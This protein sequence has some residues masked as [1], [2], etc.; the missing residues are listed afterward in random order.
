[1]VEVQPDGR[2][3]RDRIDIAARDQLLDAAK[4][5]RDCESR[6]CSTGTLRHGVA[7]RR[8]DD[9]VADVRLREVRQDGAERKRADA[10]ESEA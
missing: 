2:R 6:R 3:D 8:G 9:T 5:V 7:E 10:D 1:M 4:D